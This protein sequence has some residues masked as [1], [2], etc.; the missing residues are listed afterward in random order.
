MVPLDARLDQSGFIAIYP[1]ANQ[2]AS[3]YSGADNPGFISTNIATTTVANPELFTFAGALSFEFFQHSPTQRVFLTDSPVAFCQSGNR[4]YFYRNYGF[5]PNMATMIDDLPTTVPNRLLIADKL[6][7]D[8]LTFTY[9]PSSLRRNGIVAYELELQ[10][11]SNGAETLVVN[12]EVQIRN[13][14]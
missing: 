10:D 7:A 1:M 4:L 6:I 9:L 3:L 11:S 12:Q 2:L 13:V 8:T 14:P 5:E